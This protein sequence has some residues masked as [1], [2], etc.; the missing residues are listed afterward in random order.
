LEASSEHALG[1][2]TVEAARREGNDVSEVLAFDAIAG[3]GVRGHIDGSDYVVSHPRALGDVPEVERR[4]AEEVIAQLQE[5][6]KTSVVLRRL[7]GEEEH[8]LGVLGF[9]DRIREDAPQIVRELRRLGVERIAMLTGDARKVAD[10]IAE[11]VG[12]DDV[13]AELKPDD[14]HRIIEELE[15]SVG[16]VAMVGDGV[17]DAPALARA[18]IGIAMGAAGT[19]VALETADIVLMA[20]DLGNVPYVMSLSRSTRKTLVANLGLA[21]GL[22]LLMVAG[23]LIVNLPLPVAVFGHEGG[24][25]L[26][27]LNGLRMLLF[28][29]KRRSG[30]AAVS[31]E[32]PRSGDLYDLRG[33]H[34][35]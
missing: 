6:G 19:D 35:R 21:T 27:S 28:R 3:E 4:R 33:A 30:G 7:A 8:V 32:L 29:Y 25:V 9:A 23:I 11:Q 22:I 18:G 31:A 20:D 1:H 16:S 5:E 12:I 10:R 14:K 34:P 24:T 13:Y 17:N 15:E 26:V 2:A